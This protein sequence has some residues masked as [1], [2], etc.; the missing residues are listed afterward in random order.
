MTREARRQVLHRVRL[1]KERLPHAGLW[2]DKFLEKQVPQGGEGTFGRHFADVAN[3]PITP[4]Y[5]AFFKRWKAMLE[6][7]GARLV[8][9]HTKG[10]LVV[11][12]G[13]ASVLEN[14]IAIHHTYGVPYIPGSALKGLA[15]HYAHSRLEDERWRK[16]SEAHRVLF[17]NTEWAGYVTFFDALYVP[18]SAPQDRPLVVD[19]MTVHHPDYY[20]GED[21]APADW[22]SPTPISFV[23]AR[24][25]YLIALHGSDEWVE[26]AFQILALALEEAGIGAKTFSGYGRMELVGVPAASPTEEDAVKPEQAGPKPEPEPPLTWRRGTVRHYRPDKGFGR[27]V[28]DETGEELSFRREAIEEKGWSPGKK[29]K[30]RYAVVE[31]EGRPVVVRIRRA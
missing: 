12:L 8:M 13:A 26:A 9:A 19:V 16:S 2:L 20:R 31:Q 27:L 5:G 22:D 6:A 7:A 21:S 3:I 25:D 10:R 4:D 23:S 30:V 14:S 1:K 29:H 28:D 17:G 15:A 11:G 24:G 18:K